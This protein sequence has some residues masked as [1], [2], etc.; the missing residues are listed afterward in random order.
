MI[1]LSTE[2]LKFGYDSVI[3]TPV[4][5][6]FSA[7]EILQIKG[8]NGS[9][10]STLL[11]T[12]LGEVSK[13][14]GKI[15]WKIPSVDISYLPQTSMTSQNFNFTLGEFL[16]IYDVDQEIRQHLRPNLVDKPWVNSS[17]GEKQLAL[18][19]TRITKRTKVL[20]LDE[21]LNHLDTSSRSLVENLIK[22]LMKQK[23]DLSLIIVSHLSINLPMREIVI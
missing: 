19:L 5:L 17:G 11:K 2:K 9:G 3:G 7:G 20:I 1:Y 12:L 18:I 10:K 8:S 4:D 22:D 23:R 14:S 6:Q 15:D 16:N 13:Q 21:P